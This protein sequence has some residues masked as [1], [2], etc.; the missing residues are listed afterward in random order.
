MSEPTEEQI[1]IAQALICRQPAC[2]D[3]LCADQ[4]ADVARALATERAAGQRKTWQRVIDIVDKRTTVAQAMR[5]VMRAAREAT[6][7]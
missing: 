4:C 7:L 6:K 5:A 1:A 2:G 3:P